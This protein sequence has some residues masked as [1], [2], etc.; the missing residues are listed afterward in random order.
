[1]FEECK[2]QTDPVEAW[3]TTQVLVLLPTLGSVRVAIKA[4]A[5]WQAESGGALAAESAALLRIGNPG[6]ATDA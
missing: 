4:G 1:M 2:L 5:R 3:A 6:I